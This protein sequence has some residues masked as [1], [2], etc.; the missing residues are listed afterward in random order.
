MEGPIK[1]NKS[2][3]FRLYK[4]NVTIAPYLLH[5][6]N[7]KHGRAMSKLRLSDHNLEVEVGR[8]T[9]L[10]T[11][12]E[13]KICKLCIDPN[14]EHE[15]HFLLRCKNLKFERL[16]LLEKNLK[17]I[18]FDKDKENLFVKRMKCSITEVNI[19][20][21]KFIYDGFDKRLENLN[22]ILTLSVSQIKLFSF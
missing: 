16:L 18:N 19:K 3:T 20:L 5:V 22:N 2:L 9:K 11:N 10:K 6:K 7:R 8:H 12:S 21:A 14:I 1:P 15:V 17:Q 4:E 13:N